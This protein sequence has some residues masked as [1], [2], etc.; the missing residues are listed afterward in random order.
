MR[1]LTKFVLLIVS[2]F[3]INVAHANAIANQHSGFNRF[4]DIPVDSVKKTSDTK[5]KTP[6]TKDSKNPKKEEVKKIPEAKPKK[7]PTPVTSS[8]NIKRPK[9][10]RPKGVSIRPVMKPAGKGAAKKK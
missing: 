1:F 8:K 9:N 10:I 7:R 4:L 2:A 3:A 6:E 5:D